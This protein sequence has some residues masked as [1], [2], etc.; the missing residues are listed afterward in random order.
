M[1]TLGRMLAT[2]ER[3]LAPSWSAEAVFKRPVHLPGRVLRRWRDE[4]GAIGFEAI[5]RNCASE[6]QHTQLG[7]A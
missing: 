2:L 1:L 4:A 5:R 6:A 7:R 3:R